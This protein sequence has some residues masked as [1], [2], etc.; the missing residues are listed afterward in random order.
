MSNNILPPFIL[1]FLFHCYR[2]EEEIEALKAI[3]MDEVIV[4][5]E[6]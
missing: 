5:Q 6:E 1:T 2:V 4:K 3:L